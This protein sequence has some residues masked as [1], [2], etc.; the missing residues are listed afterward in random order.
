MNTFS[1]TQQFRQLWV[2]ILIGFV[3]L[4]MIGALTVANAWNHPISLF[5]ILT[6]VLVSLPRISTYT[7]ANHSMDSYS[8][9]V[10]PEIQF[11]GLWNTVG[12]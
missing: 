11:C 1:E 12:F 4:V 8:V 7:L 5:T 9:G 10:H 3:A 6:L 2:W